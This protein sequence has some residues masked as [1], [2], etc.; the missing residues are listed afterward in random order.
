MQWV[1]TLPNMKVAVQ[2]KSFK[3]RFKGL[4]NVSNTL[5]YEI[6]VFLQYTWCVV[7]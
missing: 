4:L 6:P 5:G 2:R 3:N 7:V 1:G